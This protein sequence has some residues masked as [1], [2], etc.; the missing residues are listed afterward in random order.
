MANTIFTVCVEKRGVLTDENLEL[1]HEGCPEWLGGPVF[2]S[3]FIQNLEKLTH[4]FG[5]KVSA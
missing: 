5:D 2:H 3:P 4:L 1:F